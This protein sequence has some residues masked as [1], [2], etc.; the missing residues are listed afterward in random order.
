MKK[1]AT[2]C[3]L[4]LFGFLLSCQSPQ[5]QTN[6]PDMPRNVYLDGGSSTVA[7]ILCHGRGQNPT[8]KVV[9]PLRKGIH[10]QLGYHTLSLQMPTGGSDEQAYVKHFP[11]AYKR[12]GA[13]IDVLRNEKG[14]KTVYLMG[15]SMGS[16]M[17]TACLSEHPESKVSGFIGVGIRNGGGPPLDS[18]RN[19]QT[20]LQR[21]PDLKVLDVYG[22]GGDKI[23]FKQ[24][25]VRSAL[26]SSRY[27]QVLVP[28]ADHQFSSREKQMVDEVVNWLKEQK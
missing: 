10:E 25:T 18:L 19:L 13:A 11:E 8:G 23:D 26:A 14:V 12:I 6:N 2:L 28:G 22:D 15:H 4:T 5:I 3:G 17:A 16:R 27:K 24:A 9:N 20:A 1:I 7:V 21:S